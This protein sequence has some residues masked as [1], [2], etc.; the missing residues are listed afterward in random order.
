MAFTTSTQLTGS[1]VVIT[2]AASGIGRAL[3]Q[4]LS[5]RGCPVAI[6]D[7]NE[8]GLAD[9]ADTLSGPVLQKKL[10]VSDKNAFYG[11]AAEVKEWAPGKV[12]AVI[13]NA[14]VTVSQMVADSSPEDDEWVFNVNYWG[15]VHG[16]T[17]FLPIF[18]DQGMGA[19]ANVSSIFGLIG[20]PSQGTY[21]ASK[22]AVRGYTE[23]L[24]HELREEPISVHTIHPGGIATNI[25]RNARFHN[26]DR[27]RTDRTELEDEFDKIAKTSPEKAAQTIIKGIEGG[28]AKIL[29]GPDAMALAGLLRVAPVRY[30][31]VIKRLEPIVRR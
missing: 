25:V 16:T 1:T 23:A 4:N 8:D 17:A 29:I 20:W 24:R 28:K 14:G 2:G 10:D 30:F 19:I 26:D 12:G 21:C 7:W 3:A 15:V 27:G 18:K 9:T 11:F 22:H 6:C 5:A 13:N 31:D